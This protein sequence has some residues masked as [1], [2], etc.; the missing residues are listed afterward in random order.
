[1]D[2]LTAFL[3]E[4][5]KPIRDPVTMHAIPGAHFYVVAAAVVF[6]GDIADIRSQ[7]E[8][9][10]TEIGVHLHYRS[11]SI[12]RRVKALEAIDRIGGWDGYLFETARPLPDANYSEHHVRAEVLI[13]AFTHLSSEGVVK[14]VLE[15][16][17]GTKQ[18]FQP[19]DKKDYEVLHKLQRQGGVPDNFQTRHDDKSEPILQVADLLAGA[20][21]DELCGV[22]RETYYR[23]SHRVRSISTVFDKRSQTRRGP[24]T[25]IRSRS[26]AYFR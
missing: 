25:T 2:E 5:R 26:G 8:L 23:I 21:S 20:R 3:D 15:T 24:G 6:D 1:M 13:E 7:L 4:S 18:E 12:S 10:S 22:D 9:V 14:A 17:A 19:L 11:L 16:R